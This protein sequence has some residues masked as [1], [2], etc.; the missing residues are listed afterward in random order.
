MGP[1]YELTDE[2]NADG[3]YRIRALRDIPL[4]GVKAGD[5]GGWVASEANLLQTGECWVFGH[6]R[7]FGNSQV[8]GNSRVSG[9]SQVFGNSQ[10]FGDSHSFAIAGPIT[11]NAQD[12]HMFRLEGGG[13]HLS[14]GCWKGTAEELSELADS[15]DWPSGG[16]ADYRAKWAPSL[17]ALAAYVQA[18]VATW[19]TK[20]P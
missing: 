19:E 8:S 12:A 13:H 9:H 6:S 20:H 16:D 3:L 5:L 14:V 10:V 18:V 1:K 11:P 17:R 15:E 2:V 7:V 4:C